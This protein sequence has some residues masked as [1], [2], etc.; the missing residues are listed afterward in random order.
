M[1]KKEGKWKEGVKYLIPAFLVLAILIIGTII[2]DSYITVTGDVNATRFFANGSQLSTSFGTPAYTIYQTGGTVYARNGT[3]GLVDYSGTNASSVI[4]NVL[5]ALSSTTGMVF[6]KRGTYAL[7]TSLNIP[8]S[9]I[10]IYG[11]DIGSTTL[12]ATTSMNSVITKS[13][14]TINIELR[15]FTVDCN[16]NAV[17]GINFTQS[18]E[19][20]YQQR[21]EY[22]RVIGYSGYAIILDGNEDTTLYGMKLESP[23]AG[24]K[25]LS[26]QN[27][28]GNV[29]IM[30]SYLVGSVDISAQ[31]AIIRDSTLPGV[32][33]T[34]TVILDIESSYSN[35]PLPSGNIVIGSIDNLI[36]NGGYFEV[37]NGNN[38]IAGTITNSI[39]IKGTQICVGSGTATLLPNNSSLSSTFYGSGVYARAVITNTVGTECAGYLNLTSVPWT[40]GLILDEVVNFNRLSTGFG[41]RNLNEAAPG[42]GTTGKVVTLPYP[43]PDA[44]YEVIAS[45]LGNASVW[46]TSKNSTAFTLNYSVAGGVAVDWYAKHLDT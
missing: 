3:T 37:N 11:E 10:S 13:T 19:G 4:Q 18:P 32:N 15:D 2:T 5:N 45:P 35:G 23:A 46:V 27:P 25:A 39:T 17:N 6:I 44:K 41:N 31:Q 36:I 7:D 33:A 21:I 28:N 42:G 38:V 26:W 16:S 24:G 12:Q 43:Y 29:W 8:Q 34:S 1:Q 20:S 30:N 22:I 14:G 40:P 9:A